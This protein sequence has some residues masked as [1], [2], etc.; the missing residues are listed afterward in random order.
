[1]ENG[2]KNKVAIS[3][4]LPSLNT[5]Q[6][7][8]Q[9]LESVTK[10]TLKNIE[11]LCVDAGSI[12]GTVEIITEYEQQD[13][14]VKKILSNIKSYG[15]QMNLGIEAANGKYIGIVE[16]DDFIQNNMYETLYNMAEEDNV[17]LI[18][19]DFY[20]F[21]IDEKGIINKVYCP[22]AVNDRLNCLYNRVINPQ[23]QKA[24]FFMAMNTWTGIYRKDFLIQNH[25]KHHESAGAAYQDNGFWFQTFVYAK[26]VKFVKGA[27]YMNRRDNPNSSVYSKDKIFAI[28]DEYNWIQRK[29]EN[30]MDHGEYWDLLQCFRYRNY[31]FHLQR[32]DKAGRRQLLE[33]F[34]MDFKMC[35]IE[36]VYL[37]NA[38]KDNLRNIL[39]NYNSYYKE[40][41]KE[42][43]D[44]INKVVQ[45]QQIIIYGTG[46]VGREVYDIL[47][48]KNMTEKIRCFTVS[49]EYK[50][51]QNLFQDKKVYS[52]EDLVEYKDKDLILI[53]TLSTIHK[54]IEQV[55]KN[56]Q[57]RNVYPVCIMG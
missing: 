44:L 22:L 19:S 27:F 21:S 17:D 42:E 3:I 32:L 39:D 41:E 56:L 1:M 51:R 43:N 2:N 48:R 53:A 24:A 15:Y 29:I 35:D 28:C 36:N 40:K 18:K 5:K 54:E 49:E 12:D 31:I 25:I 16:T 52:I 11:I 23:E 4:I 6:F 10:Q 55:L 46:M 7:I 9:C 57:F 47:Q 33:R 38:E 14:R 20:R 50:N 34:K 45:Y 8:K 30:D 26:R 37:S 13:S